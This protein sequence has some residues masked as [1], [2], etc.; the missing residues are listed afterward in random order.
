METWF[1]SLDSLS[2]LILSL[3]SFKAKWDL[4]PLFYCYFK[5]LWFWVWYSLLLKLYEDV[6]VDYDEPPPP[7]DP[8]PILN[9]DDAD[10][11]L[12]YPSSLYESISKFFP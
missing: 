3:S 7:D 10:P 12:P 6:L 8:D 11:E 2:Y 5:W 9:L 4:S 1:L